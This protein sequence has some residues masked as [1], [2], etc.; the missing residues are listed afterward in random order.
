MRVLV[1]GHQGYI[2]TV[3][4]PLLL[5]AGHHV[6]GIDTGWFADCVLG[7][8][9]AEVPTLRIDVRDVT[10]E[11]CLGADAVIHLAALC[12]DPLGGLDRDVTYEINHRATVRL[13]RAAK[14]AGVPRFLFSSSCSLYGAAPGDAAQIKAAQTQTAQIK[15]AQ[16]KAALTEDAAFAPVT[17]YGESKVLAERDIRELADETFSPVSLRNATAYGF[18]PRLRGDLVV[19]DLVAQAVLT[20]K[21]LLRSNGQAWRPLV[22]VEDIAAA[23]RALLET[24]RGRVHGRAYNVGTTAENYRISDVASIV[25]SSIPGSEVVVAEGASADKRNYRVSCDL[26]RA[27]VPEFQP[28]WTVHEGIRQLAE[29]YLRHGLTME[30]FAGERCQRL[31]AVRALRQAGRLDATLRWHATAE[32]H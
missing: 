28:R 11:H 4:V 3:L 9:P 12:N 29:S 2:G 7:P 32:T 5:S 17:A 8:A 27:E 10:P 6:T 31:L 22:H 15:A 18:S 16:I 19:N 26:I 21:V 23:F 1:T 25:A 20:G 24:P 30:A 13:A 14:A